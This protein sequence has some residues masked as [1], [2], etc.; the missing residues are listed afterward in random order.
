MR[1]SRECRATDQ[2]SDIFLLFF[3]VR[4]VLSSE[5]FFFRFEGKFLNS[6]S[7][8]RINYP[9]YQFYGDAFIRTDDEVILFAGAFENSQFRPKF[10]NSA[11]L[12]AYINS[13][14]LGKGDNE[15]R[16][17]YLVVVLSAGEFN[18]HP[19][20]DHEL[21][22]QQEEDEEQHDDIGQG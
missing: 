15:F 2:M 18:F 10:F 22:S 3:K 14:S 7:A 19:G 11:W 1:I 13:P 20:L 21:G 9:D 17:G 12:L 16:G 4:K 5:F 6:R 8:R